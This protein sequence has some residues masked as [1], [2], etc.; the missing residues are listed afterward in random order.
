M[1]DAVVQQ[2]VPDRFRDLIARLEAL[3]PDETTL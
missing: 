1:Y 3:P 2:P